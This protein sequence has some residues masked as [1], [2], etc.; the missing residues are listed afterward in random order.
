MAEIKG[1]TLPPDD[2]GGQG[3]GRGRHARDHRGSVGSGFQER[4]RGPD[5]FSDGG[6][7]AELKITWA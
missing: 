7:Y 1:A 6:E 4:H 3:E 2:R 5:L